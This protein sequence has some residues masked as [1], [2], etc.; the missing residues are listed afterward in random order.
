[1]ERLTL[2]AGRPWPLGAT[3]R[4]GGVNVAVFSAN[5]QRIELCLFDETG[6]E[7]RQRG[8]LPGHT[9][10]VFHGFLPGAAA[11]VVYGLRA[12]GPWQPAE[13]H[14]FNPHRVL[15]DPW[16]REI[17]GTFDWAAPHRDADRDAPQQMDT[18]DNAA[19]ALKAK[20][21][22]DVVDWQ[23]DAPVHHPADAVV[24]YELHVKGFTQRL[25]GV[26][27]ALRGTY[28][29]LAHPAATA[30]LQALGVTTVNLL[31]VHQH[32]DE[33][34]LHRLGLV[35]YWGY[36]TVGFF[37]PDPRFATAPD[38]TT[39]RAEFR[40]MVRALHAA[41]IAVVLDVVY[42]HTAESDLKGPSISQRGLDHASWYR[43]V[44][45]PPRWLE[46]STGCGN[47]VDLRHPR[48]LQFVLD[49]LRYWAGEMHV[50]GF[51]FDLATVLGRGDAG[52]DRRAAFFAAVQQDP[53][54][55]GVTLIAEPW[56]LGSGGYQLGQFPD[57]W[58]EWNDRFRD[59]VRGFWLGGETNRGE[60]AQRLAGSSAIFEPA[61]RRPAASV[62][63]VTSHDG[64]TLRDLVS[65][66][67]RHN[68]A[69]GENNADGHSRNFSW[70][71]GVEGPTGDPDIRALR[72]RLSRALLATVLLSQ[73]TPMLAAGDEIGRTQMGNNNAYCQDGPLSWL[74][75][76]QADDTL[77]AYVIRLLELRRRCQPFSSL[78]WYHGRT[79]VHG[80]YDVRWLRRTGKPLEHDEWS[81]PRSRVLGAWLGRPG[82][83]PDPLLLLFNARAFDVMFQVPA[84]WS[85]QWVGELD[86]SESDG[87]FRRPVRPEGPFELRAHSVVLLRDGREAAP[88]DGVRP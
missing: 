60:F 46:N 83:G 67:E 49:S 17:V 14:R 45:D 54:L 86:S 21:V 38:G 87:R 23:G 24:L 77:T 79:D 10:D 1:M 63:Y 66:N 19:H 2:E 55:A 26:P 88:G 28:L 65:Y 48:V 52:F 33:E 68:E 57:G 78:R 39:A 76:D 81:N 56:D 30:H 80:R 11:G 6:A 5:A 7:E 73:G 25:P 82:R 51:R 15:L 42:N 64:F 37:C 70:N 44:G 20:V 29:G 84:A 75:W 85:G 43:H 40:A 62:N 8:V 31:P 74:D 34:R 12:H 71:C 27:E 9:G 3:V 61:G 53:V 50:D 18:R 32:L 72:T 47:T 36:N 69:N 59:A 41:G 4:D 16:A 35:N 22:A 58:L 13:G